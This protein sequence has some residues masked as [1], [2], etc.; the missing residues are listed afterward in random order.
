MAGLHLPGNI[1]ATLADGDALVA[2]E[3]RSPEASIDNRNEWH[4]VILRLAGQLYDDDLVT[5]RSLLAAGREELVAGVIY[6][7]ILPG[8]IEL[9]EREAARLLGLLS[10]SGISAA[11]DIVG[12]REQPGLPKFSFS[13]VSPAGGG[14]GDPYDGDAQEQ[15]IITVAPLC[16]VRELYRAWRYSPVALMQTRRVYLAKCD[17]D[18][19]PAGITGRLQEALNQAGD[20]T[21]QVEVY[22]RDAQLSEYHRKVYGGSETLWL[23]ANADRIRLAS[24]YDGTDTAGNPFFATRHERIL[25]PAERENL[26]KYLASGTF[27][28]QGGA[29]Q[30]D[31]L[32]ST[33]QGAVPAGLQTDGEWVW[34]A[35]A[36]YYLEHYHLA[37]EP[38]LRQH[39]LAS[40]VMREPDDAALR[41]VR[42]FLMRH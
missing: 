22:C 9:P 36:S 11:E 27:V 40:G 23:D 31:I 30:D 33:R 39:I 25:D 4:E 21:P 37:P 32:D 14:S 2:P 10:A 12:I 3:V 8:H 13:P 38:G 16:G 7:A 18:S 24:L 28:R 5:A 15:A 35:G 26:L 19:D 41:D 17:Q 29:P 34:P 1:A 6:T 42:M 20:P